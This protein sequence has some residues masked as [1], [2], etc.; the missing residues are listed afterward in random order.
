[1]PPLAIYALIASI[2]FGS[3]FAACYRFEHWQIVILEQKID[4]ANNKAAIV[5]A[6]ETARVTA[7][8]QEQDLLNIQLESQN[9][10]NT[11]LQLDS[12]VTLNAASRVWNSHQA[13]CTNTLRAGSDKPGSTENNGEGTWLDSKQLSEG[14]DQLVPRAQIRDNECHTAITALNTIPKRLIQ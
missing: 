3:G 2:I 14:I 7:G 10:K 9:A 1:M 11:K 6:A 4:E 12:V 13:R 5:L 8:L